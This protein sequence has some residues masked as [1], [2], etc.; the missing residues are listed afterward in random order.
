MKDLKEAQERWEKEI[1][2]PLLEKKP[3]RQEEF[4]TP[5]GVE[6]ERLYTP[7]HL[8]DFQ[9]LSKLGFPGE[10]PFTRGVQPTMYRGR[11]WTMRQYAGFGT[12]EDTNKRFR[13]LLERGQTGL[14]VAFDLP[15]QMGY[16]SDHPVAHGEVGRVGVAVDSV[17]DVKRLFSG[18]D[19]ARVSTSMTIN[20][21]ANILLA[22]YI[23]TAE[24]SGVKQEQLRGT[25]QNDILK[26]Y[27]ARGT[28]I[29]PPEPSLY[30]IVD[31]MRYAAENV[32]RFNTISVSGYHIRE[33]G[34]T[35]VQEV[36]F[37]LSNGLQYLQAAQQ[38]GLDV[39]RIARRVSFFF[40]ACSNLLEEVAKFRAARRLWATLLKERFDIQDRDA[41][42]LRFHAQTAGSELTAQEP[43]NNVVRVTVQALAAAL[44][45]AQSIHTNSY[46]E[47]LSLPTEES[48]KIALRTQQILAYET[49]ITSSVDPLGG[50]YMLEALTDEI[51]N[52]ARDYIKRIDEMGGA[53]AAVERGFMQK[54]ISESAYR[55]QLEMER[56]ERVV[57]GVNMFSE[58]LVGGV[59]LLRV[60][61]AV[62]EDQK[63]RLERIRK[64][65]DK[66][67]VQKALKELRLRAT[68]RAQLMPALVECVRARC[69]LGE[70]VTV[71]AEVFGRYEG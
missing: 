27:V 13:F 18:I 33:A 45:G 50:S 58:G 44:G 5:S 6:I 2:E 63:Q 43:L 49:G 62:E 70:M 41:L 37:T 16:D 11:I 54:E 71:L 59:K 56:Q 52:R 34:A 9:Y 10:F 25:V 30:L 8:K 24:E 17:E 3:E 61:P 55:A 47:A 22:M 15:T 38:A 4:K 48:V 28:Y 21:T 68:D 46:D 65:R 19:L 12:A 53:L 36:A 31:L 29:Y 23:V 14:S 64:E 32:P 69:T 1:L 57:V 39:V 67:R 60:D 35:A 51:E 66:T 40:N 20:A 26:E 42:K 7:L